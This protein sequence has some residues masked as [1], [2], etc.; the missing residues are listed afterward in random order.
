MTL[1]D[2]IHFFLKA[3]IL[4]SFTLVSDNSLQARESKLT[5]SK[6]F[7]LIAINGKKLSANQRQPHTVDLKQ[8]LNKIA[9]QYRAVWTDKVNKVHST[10]NSKIFVVSFFHGKKNDYRL[11]FLKPATYNASLQFSKAPKVKFVNDAERSLD[12][13]FSIPYNQKIENVV[14]LTK[15]IQGLKRTQAPIMIT[16][17]KREPSKSKPFREN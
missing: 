10:I 15:L 2:K 16:S 13:N 11:T 8:G 4:L 5:L 17:K 7:N 3:I 14:K 1:L 9:L 6:E 12:L